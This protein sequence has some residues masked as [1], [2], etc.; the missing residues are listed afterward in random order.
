MPRSKP[1]RFTE[2][3]CPAID[4]GPNQPNVFF[5][6]KSSESFV[7]H[8]SRGWRDDAIQRAYLEAFQLYWSDPAHN[9]VSPV[10]GGRMIETAESAAWTW[11]ARPYPFFPGLTD[12][13]TDGANW[14]LGHWLT[15]RLGAVSLA[16]LV[17]HLC[18][19]AG[20]AEELIDVSGLW[21]A[22]EG[23]AITALESP[24]ASISMLA[25]HFGFDAVESEG[26]LRFAMR[27]RAAVGTV[28]PDEMVPRLGRRRRDGDH[29]RA[30]D[31]AAAGAEVA[32]RAAPTRTTT[33]PSS[34]RGASRSQAARVAAETL[35]G[36]GAARGGG[37]PLPPGADGGLGR[38]ARAPPSACRP[39]ASRWIRAT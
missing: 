7:P 16:A 24:R 8:F 9:P 12:V 28:A 5:D 15:G 30:G 26:R 37:A 35:P 33:R 21:G 13:W 39:R 31:R 11:D 20:L 22:V 17:R 36:G 4:R 23:Y 14:R 19:R 10:Y 32:A 18:L 34:R 25:R 6:P 1:I 3:G 38:A 27:G 29:P 2:F